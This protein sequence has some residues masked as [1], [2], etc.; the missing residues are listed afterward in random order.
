MGR[1]LR[2]EDDGEERRG[3]ERNQ[4]IGGDKI[5]RTAADEFGNSNPARSQFQFQFQFPPS[6]PRGTEGNWRGERE[7]VVMQRPQRTTNFGMFF[8]LLIKKKCL[9]YMPL[10]TEIY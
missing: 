8:S 5:K 1:V 4:P 3:E 9:F 2:G 7:R 6:L 10:F